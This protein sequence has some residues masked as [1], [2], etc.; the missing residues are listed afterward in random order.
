MSGSRTADTTLVLLATRLRSRGESAAVAET[1]RLFRGDDPVDTGTL[2]TAALAAGRVRRRGEPTR[3][4]LT[5]VGEAEL[6]TL[7][8]LETDRI[9]RADL[10][11]A[12]EAFLPLNR[13]LLSAMS[14]GGSTEARVVAAASIVAD[15][16]DVLGALAD[17]LAR[18]SGYEQRFDA[19]VARASV[20][21]TWLDGPL[22]DSVHTVWF[23]LHEHL[24]A[25]IGRD[26]SEERGDASS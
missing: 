25:T 13:R 22:I 4:S 26:R 16:R 1:V 21:P 18:F 23:E 5:A 11:T 3:W 12:Y 8:A 10:T 24:L 20:D 14:E 17:R 19:A 2:L 15:V 6:A 7:L 9:G